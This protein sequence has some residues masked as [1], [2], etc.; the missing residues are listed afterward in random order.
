ML[1]TEVSGVNSGNHAAHAPKKVIN[2]GN[3]YNQNGIQNM[4]GGKSKGFDFSRAV[5]GN[6]GVSKPV[7]S[8]QVLPIH[9]GRRPLPAGLLCLLRS[10]LPSPISSPKPSLLPIRLIPTTVFLVLDFEKSLKYNKL[11]GE[12]LDSCMTDQ[13]GS[14]GKDPDKSIAPPQKQLDCQVNREF[15]EGMRILPRSIVSPPKGTQQPAGQTLSSET[16]AREVSQIKDYGISNDQKLAITNRLCG[17]A[18]AVR[19]V[20]MDDRD[21]GDYD[22][23]EDQVKAM[24]LDYDYCIE[25]VESDDKN[26]TAQFFAA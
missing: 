21:Q 12:S 26:G 15:F 23:F 8:A 2:P 9:S 13:G 20:D 19:A 14:S 4:D 16:T 11:V 6:A 17:P 1:A 22:F 7:Q 24:G 5:N 3:A 18:K 25:D 10:P